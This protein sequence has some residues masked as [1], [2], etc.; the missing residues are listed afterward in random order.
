VL[1]DLCPTGGRG[2]PRSGYIKK[3]RTQL[4][5]NQRNGVAKR[6]FKGAGGRGRAEKN[7]SPK[8]GKTNIGPSKVQGLKH[9]A[10]PYPVKKGMSSNRPRIG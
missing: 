10:A 9:L 8:T 4:L 5:L 1:E 7:G 3:G 6:R 2:H